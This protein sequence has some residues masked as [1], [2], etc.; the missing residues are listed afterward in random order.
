MTTSPLGDPSG[1]W[2]EQCL[3]GG[4]QYKAV[5]PLPVLPTDL[6]AALRFLKWCDANDKSME[7]A[8]AWLLDEV[9]KLP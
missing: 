3:A 9:R 8:E 1:N 6:L 5:E 7:L 2:A 4:L